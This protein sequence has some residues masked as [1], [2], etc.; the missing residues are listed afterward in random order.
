MDLSETK[1]LSVTELDEPAKLMLDTADLIERRGWCQNHYQSEDGR[2]CILGA[3]KTIERI[4]M[5]GTTRVITAACERLAR[6][7][8]THAWV[9]QD[10]AGCTKEEVVAKLRAV[11]LS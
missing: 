3:M 6:H 11:A 5:H 10:Q 8:P 7:L 4:S 1:N 2:L 9:W